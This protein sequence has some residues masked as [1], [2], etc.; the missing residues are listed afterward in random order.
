VLAV[1]SRRFQTLDMMR[2]VESLLPRD[3]PD[4]KNKPI[5]DRR[6]VY[7]ERMDCQY[8]P[9]LAA[10]FTSVDT[11]WKQ[12]HPAEAAAEP[13]DEK[14]G[15]AAGESSDAPPGDEPTAVPE[16]K[17]PETN[18]APAD[19]NAGPSE[20]GDGEQPA[21]EQVADAGPQGAG[22]VVE[23]AGHH[24]HNE[25]HHKPDEATEFLR[26][27]LVRNLLGKGPKVIVSGGPRAGDTVPV[28]DLGI[29]YPVIVSSSPVRTVRI[30][31]GSGSADASG[32]EPMQPRSGLPRGR[33]AA[34]PVDAPRED[35][36]ISLRRYDFVVQFVWQPRTPG[37][38]EPVR[39]EPAG[40]E[41]SEN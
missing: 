38:P 15:E 7:I 30:A 27:T 40:T 33:G 13:L 3:P 28:G 14:A 29:G 16:E 4:E 41:E 25:P 2:A 12:T 9:D 21:G 20:G 22:W 32:G 6:E 35:D 11:Q 23:L 1:Q 34:G 17:S 24:F 39:V 36:L 19:P 31:S 10:W 26:S 5:A 18:D 37:A 8:F